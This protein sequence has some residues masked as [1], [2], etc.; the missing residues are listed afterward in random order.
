MAEK[1]KERKMGGDG[2]VG[3]RNYFNFLSVY[4]V[5]RVKKEKKILKIVEMCG[6]WLVE[7]DKELVGCGRREL[8][9]KA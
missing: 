3:D 6:T 2:K 9:I 1:W 8:L 5:E 4:L 7:S